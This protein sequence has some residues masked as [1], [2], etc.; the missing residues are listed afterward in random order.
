MKNIVFIVLVCLTISGCS[1]IPKFSFSSNNS[2]PQA[3]EKTRKI[4]K[5]NG[6]M[7][8]NDIGTVASCTSGF[9]SN[10]TNYSQKERTMTLFERIGAF[11]A[12]LRGFLGVLIL[13]SIVMVFMGMGGLVVSIWQGMFGIAGKAIKST[14]EAIKAAKERIKAN[15]SDSSAFLDE[16]SKAHSSDPEV[17]SYINKIRAEIASK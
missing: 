17:Q 15:P 3:T 14:V 6:E 5:C 9:Y 7:M 12:G 11:F 4:V 16:L 2:V 8:L 13:I 10:E 1:L